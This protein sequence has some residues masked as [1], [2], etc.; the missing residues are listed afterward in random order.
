M[1]RSPVCLFVGLLV[2]WFVVC[3][4]GCFLVGCN[5]FVLL[6]GWLFGG[7]ASLFVGRL[8]CWLVGCT[9]GW[10]VV[11]LFG[12]LFGWLVYL[13]GLLVGCLAGWLVG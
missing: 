6:V 4:V 9:S 7:R 3:Y 8:F 13:I 5:L 1:L 10:L 2:R 11:L 12:L